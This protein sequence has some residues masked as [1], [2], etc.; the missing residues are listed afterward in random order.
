MQNFLSCFLKKASKSPPEN[1]A[2]A[3]DRRKLEKKNAKEQKH[4][5]EGWEE[6]ASEDYAKW[7]AKQLEK[8]SGKDARRQAHDEF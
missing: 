8:R 2:R 4:G 7:K 6:P 1:A 3:K 5:D